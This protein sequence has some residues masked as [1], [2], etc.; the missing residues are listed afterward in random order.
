MSEENIAKDIPLFLSAMNSLKT[1]TKDSDAHIK[2]LMEKISTS[3]EDR[4]DGLSFL[5]M[6]FHLVLDYLINLTFTMILKINGKSLVEQPCIDRLVEIRTVLEK[7]RPINK[8]LSYQVDKLIKMASEAVEGQ[9]NPLSFKPN[10]N[11]LVNK[12]EEDSEGF[13]EE[14]GQKKDEVYVPP[15]VTAVPYDEEEDKQKKKME[16]AR[17]KS[18]NNALLQD[19]RNEYS[20][21]PEEIRSGRNGNMRAKLQKKEEERQRFEEDNFRRLTVTKKDR[22]MK[23]K[24]N[25]LDTVVKLDSFHGAGDDDS[26]SDMGDD[27][28]N[29][30][31][32]KGKG[33]K[34]KFK[35]KISGG[36]SGKKRRR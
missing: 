22:M 27:R 4:N 28:Y 23:R 10:L 30:K 20:E 12:D 35:K 24:L 26:D 13:E 32:K 1:I 9:A 25:D 6:K 14:D 21:A 16:K 36:G 31:K 5:E 15:R 29:P 8:K 11:N 33:K 7:I 3:E 18:L 34:D 17:Q 19:L 2:G